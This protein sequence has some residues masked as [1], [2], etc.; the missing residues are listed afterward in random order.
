M[1]HARPGKGRWVGPRGFTLGC[2]KIRQ[3][4]APPKPAW[5]LNERARSHTTPQ[6]HRP[7]TPCGADSM[8]NVGGARFISI[9]TMSHPRPPHPSAHIPPTRCPV[10]G[11]HPHL[12]HGLHE[13]LHVHRGRC[14]L[15][16]GVHDVADDADRR[17]QHD[18]GKHKGADGVR[19]LPARV[20]L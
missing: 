2:M 13:R 12:M 11:L 8:S 9:C 1:G 15:H 17:E 10:H 4:P 19:D 16:E 20:I 3:R 14:P 6:T 5:Q 7:L 18:D